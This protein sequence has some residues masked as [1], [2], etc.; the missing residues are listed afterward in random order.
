MAKQRSSSEL[1][2]AGVAQAHAMLPSGY[3]SGI[4]RVKGGSK[5][6]HWVSKARE[7]KMPKLECMQELVGRYSKGL[8]QARPHRGVNLKVLQR[9]VVLLVCLTRAALR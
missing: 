1:H 3:A 5:Y 9:L 2:G 8:P 6:H 7:S 4:E